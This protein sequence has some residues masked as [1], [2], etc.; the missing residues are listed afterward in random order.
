MRLDGFTFGRLGGLGGDSGAEMIGR[1]AVRWDKWARLDKNFSPWPYEQLASAFAAAGDRE[2]AD[3]IRY[4]ENVRADEKATGLV[5]VFCR[6][7]MRWV[8]GYGI[9]TYMFRALYWALGLSIVGAVLL[10]FWANK[11]VREADHCFVWCFGASMTCLL[12]VVGL[13]KEF[14]DFF[15]D[16]NKNKFDRHQDIVFTTLGVFG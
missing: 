12:P 14:V 1:G 11:G 9:G 3:D 6:L 5:Y 2:A 7:M 16:H 15:D 4:S 10:K 13:K 8:V